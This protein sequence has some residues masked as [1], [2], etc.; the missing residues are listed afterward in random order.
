MTLE[1][2]SRNEKIIKDYKLGFSYVELVHKYRIDSSAIFR[3]LKRYNVTGKRT[4]KP[5]GNPT[6]IA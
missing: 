4:N 2:T 5:L 1:K 3:I 6:E